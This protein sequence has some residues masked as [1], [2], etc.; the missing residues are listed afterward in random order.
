MLLAQQAEEHIVCA[1]QAEEPFPVR[2]DH[3]DVGVASAFQEALQESDTVR[4]PY[5]AVAFVS[6]NCSRRI[7]K[8]CL[9]S[10][11]V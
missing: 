9:E 8:Q 11:V 10:D 3:C 5:G 2:M 6:C 7:D 4:N 1:F